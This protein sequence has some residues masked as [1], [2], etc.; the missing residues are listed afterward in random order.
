MELR[1]DVT[2]EEDVAY[3]RSR[4]ID[5]DSD[6]LQEL[7]ASPSPLAEKETMEDDVIEPIDPIDPVVPDL[8]PR[9]TVILGQT[10]RPAWARQTLQDAEGHATPCPF[11]ESKR[12]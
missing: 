5:N 12:P 1:R 2:F 7:L 8:V 6:D 3:Q 4:C 11:W 9:D 10:R